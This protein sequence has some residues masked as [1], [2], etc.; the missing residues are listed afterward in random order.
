MA[1]SVKELIENTRSAQANKTLQSY[2]DGGGNFVYGTGY[3]MYQRGSTVNGLIQSGTIYIDESG[4][5]AAAA[6][7]GVPVDQILTEVYI[8]ELGHYVYRRDD[9]VPVA[10]EAKENWCYQ[11]EGEA[12][13][14]GFQV[15]MEAHQQGISLSVAGTNSN[16]DL[17]ATML[18]IHYSLSIF[19]PKS[20]QYLAAMIAAAGR[21]FAKDPKYSE[22]C[23]AL[24]KTQLG[25]PPPYQ[26]PGAYG[27]GGAGGTGGTGGGGGGSGGGSSSG[28]NPGGTVTVPKNPNVEM[29]PG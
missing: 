26:I 2:L 3:N 15:A 12:A 23:K 9:A 6:K 24:A 4:I 8:H 18:A 16:P 29:I 1:R 21:E 28:P 22:Y 11:R 19:D 20:N 7:R 5:A 14:F 13:V 25:A 10:P 17:Y 27:A